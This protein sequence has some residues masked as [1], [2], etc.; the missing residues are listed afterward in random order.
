MAQ[1]QTKNKGT[2]LATQSHRPKKPMIPKVDF[3][4]LKQRIARV[5]E[6]TAQADEKLITRGLS[7]SGAIGTALYESKVAPI[8]DVFG[9]D[10][11]L[12]GGGLAVVVGEV[13]ARSGTKSGRVW[14]ERIASL[15]D[16]PTILAIGEAAKR[17]SIFVR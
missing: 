14:G 17:G 7:Y 11:K 12:I 3:E 2:A 9:V 8:P 5:R 10:G 6:V 4:A 16:G 13:L 15:G 1:T